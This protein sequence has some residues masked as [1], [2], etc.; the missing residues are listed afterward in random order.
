MTLKDLKAQYG[1]SDMEFKEFPPDSGWWSSLHVKEKVHIYVHE[2]NRNIPVEAIPRG[3]KTYEHGEY[4]TFLL[5]P[6]SD[7]DQ[8][9]FMLSDLEG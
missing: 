7:E 9:T 8:E 5:V 4:D 6:K 3:R 1:I 2:D